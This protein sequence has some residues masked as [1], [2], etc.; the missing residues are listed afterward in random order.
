MP[1]AVLADRLKEHSQQTKEKL[2]AT[3]LLFRP[4]T[5]INWHR[6]L[7]RRKWTYQQKRKPGRPRIDP[8]LEYWIVR[9]AKDNPG[10]G[11]DK[12][13]GE[14]SK[15]GFFD[16]FFGSQGIEVKLLPHRAPNTNAFAERWVR[17]VREECLDQ[18]LIWNETHLR[19]V[20]IEDVNYYNT[21]RP[22]QGLGQD[23]PEGL[24]LV[25]SEGDIQYRDILDGIIHNYYRQ[26]T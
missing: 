23:S 15:L 16:T 24:K 19:R 7:V 25:S 2:E 11:Y 14:L 10:L 17:S 3:I 26:A 6:E 22:H 9:L 1:L 4:A 8:E 18:L 12:L 20:L 13:E 21:R 5:L